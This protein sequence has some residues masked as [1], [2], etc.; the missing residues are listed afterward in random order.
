M[1]QPGEVFLTKTHMIM[2]KLIILKIIK[3]A[4]IMVI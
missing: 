2:M 3:I 4:M 1:L